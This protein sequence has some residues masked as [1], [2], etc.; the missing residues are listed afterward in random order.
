MADDFPQSD[1][2]ADPPRPHARRDPPKDHLNDV[3]GHA[4]DPH[5]A[6]DA[7]WVREQKGA[8]Q[9]AG[10][11]MQFGF[12]ICIFA[13]LGNWLD[14]RFGT[15]PWLLLVGVMLGFGGGTF[16]LIRRVNRG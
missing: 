1:P 2:K 8:M 12:T 5:F 4:A 6:P 14:G 3:A 7:K 15:G 16:S 10:A 13:L 9:Y 11:G